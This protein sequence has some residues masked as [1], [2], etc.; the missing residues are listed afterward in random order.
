[1][2]LP[3]HEIAKRCII[4]KTMQRPPLIEPYDASMLQPASYDMKLGTEFIVFD[5]PDDQLM[6]DMADVHD[7]G[8]RKVHRSAA[9]GMIIQPGQ[10][11]LGVSAERVNVPGDL[12]GRLDGK[13]SMARL[14]IFIH[15]TGGNIDPGFSGDVT[16]EMFNARHVPIILRPG[17]PICQM[18][19]QELS[20]P[21]SK[22]YAGRYQDAHGVE[23]T[24]YGQ[25]LR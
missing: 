12:C 5:V 22:A 14:G 8:A 17:K 11:M 19:F 1:M 25:E 2:I 3:D 18:V 15:V 20:S 24:R 4:T 10:F 9:E 7:L 21:C 16:L 23:A 6:I 13:S